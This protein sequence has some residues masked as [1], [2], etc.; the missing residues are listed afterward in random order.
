MG[1][2]NG[3]F[4]HGGG[5][6]F[7]EDLRFCPVVFCGERWLIC[8]TNAVGNP[9]CSLSGLDSNVSRQKG[10]DGVADAL[11]GGRSGLGEPG[12]EL[13]EVGELAGAGGGVGE[14]RGE[15]FR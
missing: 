5:C 6:V 10:E 11:D 14:E 4:F 12:T 13:S 3:I 7:V 15:G 1:W 9:N 8:W 2:R